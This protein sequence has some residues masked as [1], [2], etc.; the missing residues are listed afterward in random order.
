MAYFGS[1]NT[2]DIYGSKFGTNKAITFSEDELF[3][4]ATEKAEV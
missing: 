4:M 3:I 2:H 1:G